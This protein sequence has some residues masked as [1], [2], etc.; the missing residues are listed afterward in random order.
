MPFF[1]TATAFVHSSVYGRDDDHRNDGG[2][3]HTTDYCDT[4]WPPG[5][6]TFTCT[7]RHRYHTQNRSQKVIN[8]GRRRERQACAIASYK[9]IPLSRI[10]LIKS[11]NTIPFFVTIPTNIIAPKGSHDTQGGVREQ[12]ARI[13]PVNAKRNGQHDNERHL[14]RFELSGHHNVYQHQ[15]QQ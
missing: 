10:R 6:G 3:N 2:E 7:D 15:G 14:E 8:T 1:V 11:I 4:H 13:T 9:R 12:Q 5:F